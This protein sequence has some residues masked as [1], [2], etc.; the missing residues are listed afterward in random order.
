MNESNDLISL[1][2]ARLEQ[3]VLAASIRS[4]NRYNLRDG[5]IFGKPHTDERYRIL[6]LSGNTIYY[7]DLNKNKVERRHVDELLELWDKLGVVEISPLEEVLDMIKKMLTPFIGG[8]LV[9][10]LI[11][12]LTAKMR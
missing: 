6:E 3:I 2:G 12:W 1:Y 10:A 11:S 5:R 7:K 8:A 9:G 4:L